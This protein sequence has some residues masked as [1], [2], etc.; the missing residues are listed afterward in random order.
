[1][2]AVYCAGSTECSDHSLRKKFFQISISAFFPREL[3]KI[4][5][6]KPEN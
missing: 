5:Q 6:Q 3:K 1:M 4:F 2:T